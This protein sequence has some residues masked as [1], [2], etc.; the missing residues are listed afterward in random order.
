[1]FY[2]AECDTEELSRQSAAVAKGLPAFNVQTGGDS[3]SSQTFGQAYPFIEEPGMME[4]RI[5]YIVCRRSKVDD[6][7]GEDTGPTI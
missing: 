6:T 7:E 5:M 3:G 2:G 4:A 1:M